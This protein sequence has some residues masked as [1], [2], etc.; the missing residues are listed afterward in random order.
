MNLPNW[1]ADAGVFGINSKTTI[2]GIMDGTSNTLMYG[3][4][5][6]GTKTTRS[7]VPTWPSGFTLASFTGINE[8]ATQYKFASKHTG[9]TNFALCDG[10]VRSLSVATDTQA[11]FRPL[12]T[13]AKGDLFTIN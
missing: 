9:I 12:S 2:V 1:I 13:M 5:L 8:P 3:E 11:V 4:T 7:F 10:S 6:G